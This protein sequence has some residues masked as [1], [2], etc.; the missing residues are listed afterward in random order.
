MIWIYDAWDAIANSTTS[1]TFINTKVNWIKKMKFMFIIVIYY[2]YKSI[3]PF[4]FWLM[5]DKFY[6]RLKKHYFLHI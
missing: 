4:N 1:L 3:F 2:L 6:F 5:Y